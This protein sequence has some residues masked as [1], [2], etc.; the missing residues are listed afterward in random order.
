MDLRWHLRALDIIAFHPTQKQ[1]KISRNLL[2][3][4]ARE[5]PSFWLGIR[6]LVTGR[7]KPLRLHSGNLFEYRNQCFPLQTYRLC[8]CYLHSQPIGFGRV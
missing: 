1:V 2:I 3:F 7:Q 5:L 8:G 6:A 4:L